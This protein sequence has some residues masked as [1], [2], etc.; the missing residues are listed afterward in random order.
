VALT[1]TASSLGA[2]TVEITTL[3]QA[4]LVA[5]RH[6]LDEAVEELR[7]QAET[8]RAT[9]EWSLGQWLESRPEVALAVDQALR[10]AAVVVNKPAEG[11]WHVTLQIS[12]GVLNETLRSSLRRGLRDDADGRLRA[13]GSSPIPWEG[14][15]VDVAVP[16]APPVEA[17]PSSASENL[18]PLRGLADSERRP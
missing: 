3:G 12:V 17:R 9:E 6:A 1:L 4:Q 2:G 5:R 7:V 16:L 15:D 10:D 8:L 18:P 13:H 14:D 11:R